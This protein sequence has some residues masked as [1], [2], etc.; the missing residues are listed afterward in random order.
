MAS[1]SATR[2]SEEMTKAAAEGRKRKSYHSFG[3]DGLT[4]TTGADLKIQYIASK[5][6]VYQIF[7]LSG[8]G[9]ENLP[10]LTVTPDLLIRRLDYVDDKNEF[11]QDLPSSANYSYQIQGN[12]IIREHK[13][14]DA[15]VR[16]HIW[17]LQEQLPLEF[18]RYRKSKIDTSNS[19]KGNP[20]VI[21]AV[22]IDLANEGPVNEDPANEDLANEDPVNEGP[23][24]NDPVND[25][26]INESPVNDESTIRPG[27]SRSFYRVSRWSIYPTKQH[28]NFLI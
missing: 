22:S 14:G 15:K 21:G 12:C 13:T 17:A 3:D 25:G 5:G 26:L 28:K 1:R 6:T 9:G 19:S 23:V 18:V 4:A 8:G 10:P 11:N 24:N 27:A 2:L 16:L 20:A 7:E